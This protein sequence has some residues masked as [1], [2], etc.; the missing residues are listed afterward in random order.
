MFQEEKMSTSPR[1]KSAEVW[2]I[3]EE[4]G[5]IKMWRSLLEQALQLVRSM[6]L[7][8]M[9]RSCSSSKFFIFHYSSY[10]FFFSFK[11][12]SP[13]YFNS[14]KMIDEKYLNNIL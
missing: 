1:L 7:K 12:V 5:W 9:P 14:I 13:F 8:E 2:G 10:P 4:E 11:I 3:E 6:H